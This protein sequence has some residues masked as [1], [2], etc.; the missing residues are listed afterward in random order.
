MNFY[1]S[2]QSTVNKY[3]VTLK[4]VKMY[5]QKVNARSTIVYKVYFYNLD[6]IFF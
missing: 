2:A 6:R 3:I 4:V 1:T 5:T